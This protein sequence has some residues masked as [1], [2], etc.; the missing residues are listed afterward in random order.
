MDVLNDKTAISIVVMG[1]SGSGKS[2]IGELL[3]RKLNCAFI[4]ADD[5]HPESNKIAMS[6]GIALTDK[7]RLPWLRIVGEELRTHSLQKQPLIVACSALKRSYR[8]LLRTYSPNL[9]FVFLEGTQ[10]EIQARIALRS[11]EFM[12][13]SLL[14]SQFANLEPLENDEFG[15]RVSV[16]PSTEEICQK[17]V[18]VVLKAEEI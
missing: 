10:E 1:V 8:E 17:I 18:Q 6:S 14:D 4:D 2:T 5:L 3:S 12:P 15:L 9:Y 7:E 11:H 13:T 16:N